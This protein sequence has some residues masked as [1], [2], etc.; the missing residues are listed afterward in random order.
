MADALTVINLRATPQGEK[1][2]PR[3]VVN[4]A[5]G[6]VFAVSDLERLRR[7]LVLGTE[8]GT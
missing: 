6:H 7:F 8:G 5:G 1:A 3:Q 2:D 4:H